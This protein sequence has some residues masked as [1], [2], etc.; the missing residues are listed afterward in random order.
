M[1]MCCCPGNTHCQR[2]LFHL[3]ILHDRQLCRNRFRA[4]ERVA[5][6]VERVALV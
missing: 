3:D 1:G 6:A 2:I 4:V 5:L